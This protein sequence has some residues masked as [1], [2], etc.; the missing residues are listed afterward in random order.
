MQ[1]RQEKSPSPD[2][3]IKAADPNQKA[4]SSAVPATRMPAWTAAMGD[5]PPASLQAK[6]IVNQPGDIYEQEAEHVANQVMHGNT[7]SA[8][9]N[10]V[11]PG[12]SGTLA[13]VTPAMSHVSPMIQRAP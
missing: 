9:M 8:S 4:A 3:V 1:D 5:Q 10:V 11:T 12:T 7:S 6:L 2:T 13:Q